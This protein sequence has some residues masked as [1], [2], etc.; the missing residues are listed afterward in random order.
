MVKIFKTIVIFLSLGL[1]IPFRVAHISAIIH[2]IDELITAIAMIL[3]VTN[4][5]IGSMLVSCK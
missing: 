2:A 4:C 5:P 1:A 3:N